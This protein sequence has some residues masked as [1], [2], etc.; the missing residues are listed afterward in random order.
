L[1]KKVQWNVRLRAGFLI[2]FFA[3]GTANEEIEHAGNLRKFPASSFLLI[4]TGCPQ[5]FS[6]KS[7]LAN[8]YSNK[9]KLEVILR[10]Q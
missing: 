4:A 2:V 6:K 3:T 9:R 5:N 8:Q 1:K 10:R 7:D